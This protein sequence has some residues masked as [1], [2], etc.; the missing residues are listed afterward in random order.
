MIVVEEHRGYDGLDKDEQ[1]LVEQGEEEDTMFP[2]SL[3]ISQEEDFFAW[4]GTVTK[5]FDSLELFWFLADRNPKSGL[6]I[7]LS[8]MTQWLTIFKKRNSLFRIIDKWSDIV[9]FLFSSF[10]RFMPSKNVSETLHCHIPYLNYIDGNASLSNLLLWHCYLKSVDDAQRLY[11]YT[12]K[13]IWF[14]P[15]YFFWLRQSSG[16][17]EFAGI[18]G[19]LTLPA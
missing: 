7:F 11:P 1:R 9:A 12:Q 13:G 16:M 18:A 10:S 14:N 3:Y 2:L 8:Q 17:G 15:S 6:E 5:S 4:K 19:R